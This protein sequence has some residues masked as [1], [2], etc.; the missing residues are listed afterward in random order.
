MPTS[1]M[2]KEQWLAEV[3]EALG[4]E[5]EDVLDVA[6]MFFVAID[7]RL[8]NM[9]RAYKAGDM[10]VLC[11]LAHGLKGDAASMRFL[12]SSQLARELEMQSRAGTVHDFQGQ[13]E[14][15]REALARQQRILALDDQLN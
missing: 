5:P 4:L 14:G 10:N 1:L 12:E 15:L 7:E 11:R 6:V 3:T 9:D 13:L 8:D 2:S